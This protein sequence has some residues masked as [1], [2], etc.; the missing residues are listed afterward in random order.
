MRR[1][2][3]VGVVLLALALVGGLLAV[4]ISTA[5]GIR[6]EP[7]Q[8]PVEELHAAPPRESVAPPR[9]SVDAPGSERMSAAL[10]E[11]ADATS[12][13][14]RGRATLV[15]RHGEGDRDDDSYR[16]SGTASHM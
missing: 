6:T 11:L 7:K 13:G 12:D 14:T 10:D 16:L 2:L 1:G 3:Q 5:L 4:G 8:V 15:V 9:I